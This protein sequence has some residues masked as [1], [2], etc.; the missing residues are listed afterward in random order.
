MGVDFPTDTNKLVIYIKIGVG[1]LPLLFIYA[2]QLDQPVR[3]NI[4]PG[5]TSSLTWSL[6]CDGALKIP[7]ISNCNHVTRHSCACI[8][9]NTND[10]FFNIEDYF[11]IISFLSSLYSVDLLYLYLQGDLKRKRSLHVYIY[12]SQN[13]ALKN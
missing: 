6:L 8:F 9:V 5:F 11:D 4:L 10:T 7:T 1:L 2:C 13:Y 3:L 12:V